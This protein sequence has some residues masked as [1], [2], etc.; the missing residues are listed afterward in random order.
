MFCD[1]HSWNQTDE[2][3]LTFAKEL[4]SRFYKGKRLQQS[5]SSQ[6]QG[7]DFFELPWKKKKNVQ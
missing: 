1:V 5:S 6:P 2:K 7:K 3:T 4:T